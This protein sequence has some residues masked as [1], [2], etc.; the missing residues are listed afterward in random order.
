LRETDVG[1]KTASGPGAGAFSRTVRYRNWSMT[2]G[3][4]CWGTASRATRSAWRRL[5]YRDTASV[6]PARC[7]DRRSSAVSPAVPYAPSLSSQAE[8]SFRK[9][10]LARWARNWAGVAAMAV[11]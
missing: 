9:P 2:P 5:K 8:L 6:S 1:E 10:G 7:A 4:T 11:K 3:E